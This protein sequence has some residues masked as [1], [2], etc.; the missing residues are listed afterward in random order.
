M[1]SIIVESERCCK[2]FNPMA[3]ENSDNL[4]KNPT[5]DDMKTMKEMVGKHS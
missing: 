4:P 1:Y 5:P 2:Y 3:D